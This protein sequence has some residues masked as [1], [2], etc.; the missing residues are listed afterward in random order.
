MIILFVFQGELKVSQKEVS[1]EFVEELEVFDSF[2]AN[3]AFSVN[4]CDQSACSPI[5]PFVKNFL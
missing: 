4:R 5:D 1:I 2:Y 3:S